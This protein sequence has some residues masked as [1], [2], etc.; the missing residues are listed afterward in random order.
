M[1]RH[2]GADMFAEALFASEVQHSS[3]TMLQ[4]DRPA[5][6]TKLR[7]KGHSAHLKDTN[8]PSRRGHEAS[9]TRRKGGTQQSGPL[10]LQRHGVGGAPTK[11]T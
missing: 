4:L 9:A 10:R 2:S 6:R 1:S 3:C 11:W 5:V 8:K 7:A